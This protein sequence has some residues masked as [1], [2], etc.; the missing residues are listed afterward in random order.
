[1]SLLQRWSEGM[2]SRGFLQK[3]DLGS[4]CSFA[5]DWLCHWGKFFFPLGASLSLREKVEFHSLPASIIEALLFGHPLCSSGWGYKDEETQTRSLTDNN[6]RVIVLWCELSGIIQI[7]GL[8]QNIWVLLLLTLN[9]MW[10]KCPIRAARLGTW[11]SLLKISS[12]MR[13][14]CSSYSISILFPLAYSNAITTSFSLVTSVY[15]SKLLTKRWRCQEIPSP[16]IPD[17][18]CLVHS[19]SELSFFQNYWIPFVHQI[20]Y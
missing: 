12:F 3:A 1:M 16:L 17:S 19:E 13:R 5:T 8:V 7:K 11:S 15:L 2:K 18:P 4:N 9:Y 10:F 6:I 20:I 14:T